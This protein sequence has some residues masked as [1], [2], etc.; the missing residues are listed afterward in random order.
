M[1]IGPIL[2]RWH[3]CGS[4][5]VGTTRMRGRATN[6]GNV[7]VMSLKKHNVVAARNFSGAMHIKMEEKNM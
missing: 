2:L 1:I 7:I 4:G 3:C 5:S 6:G